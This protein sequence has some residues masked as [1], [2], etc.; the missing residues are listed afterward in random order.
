MLSHV[1]CY[2]QLLSIKGGL[3][4]QPLLECSKGLLHLVNC[5][6]DRKIIFKTRTLK[7]SQGP[8]ASLCLLHRA[9]QI[10]TASH[11]DLKPRLLPLIRTL[12]FHIG[13]HY[14]SLRNWGPMRANEGHQIHGTQRIKRIKLHTPS[15]TRCHLSWWPGANSV[16]CPADGPNSKLCRLR[17]EHVCRC[18]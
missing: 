12:A 6:S 5:F 18:L 10:L 7:S 17:V 2:I 9:S 4:G 8:N 3:I 1:T 13:F 14:V 11:K 15:P 16:A